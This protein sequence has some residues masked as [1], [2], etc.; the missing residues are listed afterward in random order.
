MFLHKKGPV[1]RYDLEDYF[2]Y[3]KP[4][5]RDIETDEYLTGADH[6]FNY[7]KQYIALQ[8]LIKE[9]IIKRYEILYILSEAGKKMLRLK[10]KEVV[11]H[12]NKMKEL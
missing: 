7:S 10:H 1:Y 6:P 5:L 8:F 4:K 12:F 9:G 3:C 2:Y 11:F